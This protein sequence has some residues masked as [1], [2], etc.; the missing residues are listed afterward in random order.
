MLNVSA[1]RAVDCGFNP[2][3]IK[4]KTIKLVFVA[5]PLSVQH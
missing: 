3:W 5:T 1:S 4:P 2:C